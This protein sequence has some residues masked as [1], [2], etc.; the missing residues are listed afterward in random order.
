MILALRTDKPIA[1]LTLYNKEHNKVDEV[2][3]EADRKLADTLLLKISE[4]VAANNQTLLDITGVVIFTGQGSFTGLRIGT[5]VANALGFSLKIP[6]A[7]GRGEDWV[8]DGFTQLASA[9]VGK[10][11]I[12]LYDGEANITYPN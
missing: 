9:Q 6:V 7:L 11:V 10:S 4:I 8:E 1:E 12:P 5:S 3:W 2:C